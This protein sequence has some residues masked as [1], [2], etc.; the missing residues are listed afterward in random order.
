MNTS[1]FKIRSKN[2]AKLITRNFCVITIEYQE[3]KL[4]EFKDVIYE[5]FK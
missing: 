3:R 4:I 2:L 5:T 1:Y